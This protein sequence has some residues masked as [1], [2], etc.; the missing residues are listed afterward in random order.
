MMPILDRRLCDRYWS[1]LIDVC[2]EFCVQ[3]E[4]L[5]FYFLSIWYESLVDLY[6]A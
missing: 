4:M 2:L 5:F 3:Q 6:S 1:L